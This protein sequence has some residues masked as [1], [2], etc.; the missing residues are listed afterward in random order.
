MADFISTP[1]ALDKAFVRETL[2]S[3]NVSLD[4]Q[5]EPVNAL[6]AL[7]LAQGM[8]AVSTFKT[9]ATPLLPSTS[10]NLQL[11]LEVLVL[12]STLRLDGLLP[13][14]RT[15]GLPLLVFTVVVLVFLN[16]YQKEMPTTT[17]EIPSP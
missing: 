14:N 8:V 17:M 6:H 15:Q 11:H 10:L 4:T 2:A 7:T 13:E 9:L 5:E 12:C 16:M 3:A 1:S